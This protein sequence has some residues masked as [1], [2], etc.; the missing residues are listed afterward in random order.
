MIPRAPSGS[1]P[2][3]L[4]VHPDFP[5]RGAEEGVLTDG[6]RLVPVLERMVA[7]AESGEYHVGCVLFG[8]EEPAAP[9][10]VL[11]LLRRLRAATSS[12]VPAAE[13]ESPRK[14]AAWLAGNGFPASAVAGGFWRDYCVRDMSRALG[15]RIDDRLTAER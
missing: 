3:L 7:A 11:A 14:A 13:T 5:W 10:A 2:G 6:R 9:G 4:I 1:R 8:D 15:V 12:L